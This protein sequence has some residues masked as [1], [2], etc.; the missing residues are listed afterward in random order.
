M[1]T[2]SVPD[3]QPDGK[4]IRLSGRPVE[5]LP[6][7]RPG[8]TASEVRSV[9]SP[10]DPSSRAVRPVRIDPA[11]V[12][13]GDR[14]G[15]W[16]VE[17]VS[18]HEYRHHGWPCHCMWQSH[19]WPQCSYEDPAC[20]CHSVSTGYTFTCRCDCGIV[21]VVC[22]DCLITGASLSCG[23]CRHRDTDSHAASECCGQPAERR[24]DAAA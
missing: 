9:R 6:Q 22:T 7:R 10:V 24:G 1:L 17:Y 14:I 20:P 12:S 18:S 19:T 15:C 16:L 3:R 8:Q 23:H 11:W 4:P 21:R 5:W 13:T 2:Y